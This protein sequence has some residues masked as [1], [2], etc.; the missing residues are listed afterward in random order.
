MSKFIAM[1]ST[2]EQYL[3]N[4]SCTK[5]SKGRRMGGASSSKTRRRWSMKTGLDGVWR[6]SPPQ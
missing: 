5:Y 3:D 4:A 6:G 2:A 1:T